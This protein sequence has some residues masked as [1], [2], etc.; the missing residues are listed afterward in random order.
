MARR[1]TPGATTP[2]SVSTSAETAF[3]RVMILPLALQGRSSIS[4]VDAADQDKPKTQ[5][6]QVFIDF[7][8][9]L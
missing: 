6:Y 1:A 5:R 8:I 7:P 9:Q 4:Y 2:C 3:M